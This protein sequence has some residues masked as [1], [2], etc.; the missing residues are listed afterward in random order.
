M[1]I[2]DLKL[3]LDKVD[4]IYKSNTKYFIKLYF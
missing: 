4:N 2:Y 1:I 3:S